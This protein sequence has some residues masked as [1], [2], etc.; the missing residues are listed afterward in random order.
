[1]AKKG[2][3]QIIGSKTIKLG[4][5]KN[6][7]ITKVYRTQDEDKLHHAKWKLY[8]KENNGWRELKPVAGTPPK[9]GSETTIT[10]TNQQLL[11][12]ELLL[13]AYLYEPEKSSLQGI[14]IKVEGGNKKIE[15]VDLFR[16][17]DS[18][19]EQGAILKYGQSIMVKVF[20][21]NMPN[22]KVSISLYED[23][24]NGEG[25][26]DKND[27]N[28]A[29][30][31][32]KYLD[33]DGFGMHTFKLPIDFQRIANSYMDGTSDKY[34]EYYINVKSAT[35]NKAS[36]NIN[37]P[38]PDYTFPEQEIEE[39]VINVKAKEIGVDPMPNT[40]RSVSVVQEVKIEG[41]TDAYF[42]KKEYTKQTDEEAGTH[43]YTFANANANINKDNIAKIIKDKTNSTLK[44][45]KKYAKLENVKTALTKTSY[46]K[47]EKI[48]FS[49]FKLGA[50]FKKI[51]SAAIE[52]KVYLVAKTY[53][54]N[55]KEATITIKEK[56]GIIKGSAYASLP[57]LEITEE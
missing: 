44:S 24:E 28:K 55:G 2:I 10:I 20:T 17:D 26:S 37:V 11:G 49:V 48:S 3:A 35:I 51:D 7:R 57:V 21:V 15:R 53:V 6:Y 46:T 4:E 39:V 16:T 25:H 19:I 50:D 47:G 23:D 27:K 45:S 54:L 5:T 30:F 41:V 29:D 33:E 42:A 40:G 56:D 18:K 52:D 9:V 31:V 43:E 12:K 32:E 22:E 38:N 1:M 36:K 13:E 8:V 34:H 14:I